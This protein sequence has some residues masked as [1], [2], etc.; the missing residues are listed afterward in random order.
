MRTSSSRNTAKRGRTT[1]ID[2]KKAGRKFQNYVVDALLSN[3]DENAKEDYTR[4]LMQGTQD[5]GFGR[6]LKVHRTKTNSIMKSSQKAAIELTTPQS[7]SR[8]LG[9]T[10]K[11]KTTE[12]SPL[13]PGRLT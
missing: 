8:H 4:F 11:R 12:F 7:T 6:D 13:S 5:N 2:A 1:N 10:G 3:K 9:A